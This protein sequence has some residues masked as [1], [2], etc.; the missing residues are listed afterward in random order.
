MNEGSSSTLRVAIVVPAKKLLCLGGLLWM[1]R[2]G[3]LQVASLVRE[4]GYPVQLFNEE[5][6]TRVSVE[7][8]AQSFDVIGF[9]CKTSALSRAEELAEAIKNDAA[10]RGR[11]VVTVLGGE[12][13]SMG[14]DNLAHSIV[15]SEIAAPHYFE[16]GEEVEAP[17]YTE[18][19]GCVELQEELLLR[20]YQEKQEFLKGANKANILYPLDSRGGSSEVCEVPF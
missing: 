19:N 10:R 20:R 13:I 3:A 4:A 1:Q 17:F 5:L 16:M 12:H 18:D 9:S 7:Q 14:G 2:Y 11:E 8:L 6:G 15:Q